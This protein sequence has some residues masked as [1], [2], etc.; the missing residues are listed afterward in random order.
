VWAFVSDLLTEPE[1]I[2]VG[3]ETLIEQE[4]AC[5]PRDLDRE[6]KAWTRK[7]D[8]CTHLRNAYQDQQAAGFMTLQEL[9]S[10][11]E[12]LEARR[13]TA[14]RKLVAL[15]SHQQRVEELEQDRDAL[16]ESMS[17]MVPSAL[18]GL[19]GEEK[20]RLYRMLCLE[21]TPSEEGYEVSGA[22]CTSGL[23]SS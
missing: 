18:E 4:Q 2:R 19:T 5:A 11:L 22:F 8:E 1:K 10:K 3:M 17:E 9:G 6:A 13:K 23:T 20:N 7:M 12:E 16:L 14:E 15:R 21:V